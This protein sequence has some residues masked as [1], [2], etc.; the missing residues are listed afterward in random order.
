[1]T[2][3]GTNS[4]RHLFTRPRLFLL[5]CYT[6]ASVHHTQPIAAAL[7]PAVCSVPIEVLCY[8]G[9]ASSGYVDC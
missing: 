5:H 6:H 4:Y 1:M 3:R 2:V 8:V 9:V 7:L